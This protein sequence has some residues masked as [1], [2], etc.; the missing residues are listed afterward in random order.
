M[1]LNL[2]SLQ[3]RII[4]NTSGEFKAIVEDSTRKTDKLV[5]ETNMILAKTPMGATE[6]NISDENEKLDRLVS[7]D[8]PFDETQ[9]AAVGGMAGV[10]YGCMIG[11]AGTGKTTVT[12]KLVD[13]LRDGLR[14]VD[15]SQYWSKG[16]PADDHDEYVRPTHAIPSILICAFTGR[17]TQ[18]IKKNFP[19]SWHGNIMTIH[20]AL[21]FYPEFYDDMDLESQELVRKR[22][23][24]P[25][26]T[27][28]N[29]MPWDIILIDEAGMLGLEL[30]HQLYA[31]TKRGCRIYM[32][33]DINQLQPT[34]GKSILGFAM[35]KWPTWELTHVHRQSG[36][37]NS[38]VDNAHRVLKG[39]RPVS[40]SK[41]KL[42]IL[43]PKNKADTEESNKKFLATLT[44][45][46]KDPDW[47]F[48]TVDI[49]EN[50]KLAS[51]RIRQMLKLLNGKFYE[52]NRD[53]VIT[54]INGFEN[55]GL[56]S[57]LGQSPMNQELVTMINVTDDRYLIDAGREK[58]NFAVGDKVMATINDYEAGITNGMTGLITSIAP[59]GAYLG[60]NRRFGLIRE[61]NEYFAEIADDSE[62]EDFS[63][64][65]IVGDADFGEKEAKAR[66]KGAKGPASHIV[67]VQFGEGEH[68]FTRSF[69]SQAKV[70]SLM[71]AYF[72]T[73]H[74]MQGGE[75]PLVFIICHQTN[76]MPLNREW[77]Y[78]AITRGS[79]KV[80]LLQT[81]GGVGAALS[82]QAIKGANLKAKLLSFAKLMEVGI[83]GASLNVKLPKAESLI[84]EGEDNEQAT[85]E[86]VP[87]TQEPNRA[88]YQGREEPEEKPKIQLRNVTI[89][90]TVQTVSAPEVRESQPES[91]KDGGELNPARPQLPSTVA[92]ER[93]THE[94]VLSIGHVRRETVECIPQPGAY[95]AAVAIGRE[96]AFAQRLL[97][98]QPQPQQESPNAATP[99]DRPAG[100][101]VPANLGLAALLA[102]T[103]AKA[104]TAPKAAER[105][106][107][108]QPAPA[109]PKNLLAL[110][111]ANKKKG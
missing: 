47:R 58:M 57:C 77:L 84:Q 51:I 92:G 14:M 30:W 91:W 24:V 4:Q 53:V 72:A 16:E 1:K 96:L 67:T 5:G 70:G 42:S 6:V 85:E 2:K 105:V 68:A 41:E 63:L 25:S 29:L 55:T 48:L 101:P 35:N 32:I 90:L 107:D 60:D 3:P 8:F 39:L 71:L 21:G 15:L 56:G 95:H 104:Q 86:Q 49:D 93:T 36:A 97:T 37:N 28:D 103:K 18:Q 61:V 46:I 76:K 82:K 11:A 33:G 34:H 52:P 19:E 102:K 106:I 54:P 74:K 26:Y 88:E 75:C 45:M 69:D 64:D 13:M 62:V 65:D 9:L 17:A 99:V 78:T 94:P 38:I 40:D 43:A 50:P 27:A 108:S 12:K 23:F 44:K 100:K 109:K 7:D 111:A 59:N 98:Y 110:L 79:Q 80:V 31:A 20:R 87:A 83:V 66:E 81:S 89:N 73:C 22:R 10:K